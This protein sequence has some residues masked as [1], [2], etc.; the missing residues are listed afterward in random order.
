MADCYRNCL[1]LAAEHDLRS[2]AFP[3]I[4][5]G[6][7]GFP[8]ELAANIAVRVTGAFTAND[9]QR[10]IS[11]LFCCFSTQDLAIYQREL[12]NGS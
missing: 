2:I 11:I 7:Y 9:N 3:A 10:P 1:A 6:A 12:Q 4:S 5:T 8:I